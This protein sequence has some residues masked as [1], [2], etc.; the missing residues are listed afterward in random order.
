MEVYPNNCK[1]KEE[2]LPIGTSRVMMFF[3]CLFFNQKMV[4]SDFYERFLLFFFPLI[5]MNPPMLSLVGL[6]SLQYLL[7]LLGGSRCL[8]GCIYTP[9]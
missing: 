4:E 2:Q 8:H 5:L 3:V 9:I 1:G 7:S 6:Y